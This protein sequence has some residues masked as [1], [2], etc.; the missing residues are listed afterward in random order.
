MYMLH[1]TYRN[2]SHREG[3]LPSPEGGG[4]MSSFEELML[5]ISIVEFQ[6]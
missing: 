3:W 4:I 6:I 2:Q 1:D 5:I